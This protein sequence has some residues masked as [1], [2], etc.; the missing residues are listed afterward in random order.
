MSSGQAHSINEA[1]KLAGLSRSAFYKYKDSVHAFDQ[2]MGGHIIT[3]NALLNDEVGM[4]SKL[5]AMLYRSGANIL[6]INQS[7]PVSGTASVSVTARIDDMTVPVEAMLMR[8]RKL[9]GVRDIE[10]ATGL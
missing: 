7:I 3:L 6:T 5:I 4:L 9:E 1:T 2:K 10:I 8:V